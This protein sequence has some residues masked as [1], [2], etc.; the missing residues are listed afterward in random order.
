MTETN[1]IAEYQTK[2]S[3]IDVNGHVNSIKYIE[4]ILDLFPLEQ[5]KKSVYVALKWLIGRKLLW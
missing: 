3:D 4:H 1:P 2:Y 5:F